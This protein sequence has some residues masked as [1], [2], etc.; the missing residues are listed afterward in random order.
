MTVLI[1]FVGLAVDVGSWYGQRRRMQNAADA[2]ALAAAFE[3][4]SLGGVGNPANYES[5]AIDYAQ[6]NGAEQV[7]V[8]RV[9]KDGTENADAGTTVVVS[10]TVTAPTFF[11][12][13]VLPSVQVSAVA[14]AACGSAAGG[15][16]A[17]PIAFD[18]PTYNNTDLLPCS[19][20][21]E[22]SGKFTNYR[23]GSTFILWSEDNASTNINA[24]CD[25]CMCGGA[26]DYLYDYIMAHLDPLT[27]NVISGTTSHTW[28]EWQSLPEQPQFIVGGQPMQPGNR[29]WLSLGLDDAPLGP[30]AGS[31]NDCNN[32]SNCGSAIKCWIKYGF[33]GQVGLTDPPMCLLGQTG[34]MDSV[35]KTA[36]IAIENE[37]H[38]FVLYDGLCGAEAPIDFNCSSGGGGTKFQVAGIGCGLVLH[39]FSNKNTDGIT[40]PNSPDITCSK[41]GHPPP[42]C[43]PCPDMERGIM[44][45]KVCDCPAG[46]CTG[47]AGDPEDEST[48]PGVSLVSVPTVTWPTP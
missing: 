21:D 32:T 9:D 48:P 24:L 25:K 39:V 10:A 15:C 19:D 42:Q 3:L 34:V 11:S 18:A 4:C 45:T 31:D 17:L 22:A 27:T 26:D 1:L 6:R 30:E 14:A 29:G 28:G 47:T 43:D 38:S 35:L 40:M 20:Y 7:T 13:L 16:G 37:I 36:K 33:P 2:G 46:L 12:R 23:V 5:S 41:N 8:L 44:V